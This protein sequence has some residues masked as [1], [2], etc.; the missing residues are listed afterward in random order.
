MSYYYTVR[1]HD[2]FASRSDVSSMLLFLRNLIIGVQ[3]LPCFETL[4]G[5]PL[6][7][8]PT[9]RLSLFLTRCLRVFA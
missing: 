1:T 9:E 5:I 6:L 7:G 8:F 4:Y 3:F 2:L